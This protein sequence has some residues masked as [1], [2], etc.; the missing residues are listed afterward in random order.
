MEYRASLIG[1]RVQI[2]PVPEGGTCVKLRNYGWVACAAKPISLSGD[3]YRFRLVDD[4]LIVR[5]GLR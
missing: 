4:H 5:D 3:S 1:G 2:Q